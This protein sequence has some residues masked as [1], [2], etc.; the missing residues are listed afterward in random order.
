MA[1]QKYHYA[2]QMNLKQANMLHYQTYPHDKQWK[3]EKLIKIQLICF[4]HLIPFFFLCVCV[5]VPVVNSS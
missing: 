5:C 1:V 4:I 2:K 3:F